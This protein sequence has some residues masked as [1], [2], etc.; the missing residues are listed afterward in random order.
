M[1]LLLCGSRHCYCVL[2][3]SSAKPTAESIP[4]VG[5]ASRSPLVTVLARGMLSPHPASPVC[6]VLPI[7]TAPFVPCS[8][9]ALI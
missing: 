3:K 8:S 6:Q 4:G 2:S 5:R 1:L 7:S 9:C